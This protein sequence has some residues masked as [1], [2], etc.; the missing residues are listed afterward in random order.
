[1]KYI[2]F[3][4]SVLDEI[5]QETL[6][7]LHLSPRLSVD[8]ESVIMKVANYELLFPSVMTLPELG[9]ETPIEPTY[10][11]PTYEGDELTSLLETAELSSEATKLES[12]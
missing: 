8:G 2:V 1:M 3:P 6:N 12:K 10:P 11:Y 7:E 9:D 4:K 5:P